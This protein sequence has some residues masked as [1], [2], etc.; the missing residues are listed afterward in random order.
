[1]KKILISLFAVCAVTVFA[2]DTLITGYPAT[3]GIGTFKVVSDG[4]YSTLIVDKIDALQGGGTN[5]IA[6]AGGVS[7]SSSVATN[8]AL[9]R[10]VVTATAVVTPLTKTIEYMSADGSTNTLAVCTNATVAVTVV[11]GG[12]V[13]TNVTASLSDITFVTGICTN[14]P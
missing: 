10:A 6:V 14:K 9:S 2:A 7:G 5:I 12:L 13:V 3:T 1:M 8:V 4:T 11:N